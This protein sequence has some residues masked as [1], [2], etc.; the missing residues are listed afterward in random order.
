MQRK[1]PDG[2]RPG[3]QQMKKNAMFS[4]SI[5]ISLMMAG[6]ASAAVSPISVSTVNPAEESSSSPSGAAD[7]DM[8]KIVIYTPHDA[9]PMNAA[10][11]SFMADYP[12]IKVEVVDA[13][14]G[15]L[16]E[17]V[18][19]EAEHPAADVIWG[20]G[21]DS[22]AGHD[23][24][25]EAYTGA[26][27]ASIDAQFKDANGLWVGESP[28]PMVIIYNKKLLAAAGLPYPV[29]WADCLN[30][31]F[32][33]QIAYCQPSKSGSAYTQLCTM[34]LANGGQEDGWN[35]VE[36]FVANLDGKIFDSSSNCHKQV[37]AGE[38]MLGI[39][40]EKSAMT[41]AD[42]PDI[43]YCYPSEGTSSVPDAI[44]IIKNCPDEKNAQLFVDYVTSLQCQTEQSI[45]WSRR[46]V[47][48]DV[49]L[50][51]NMT[52]LSDINMVTYDFSWAAN[53]RN[54]NIAKFDALWE[55][56]QNG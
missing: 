48:T 41:Y 22:L 15:E 52:P 38:F 45:D 31:A 49:P 34:I 32:K 9:D 1:G 19:N 46:P 18:K 51:E 55:S 10:I 43:G 14:T 21:A 27:D 4:F 12:N 44:A 3:E 8:G 5:G 30:P 37:A 53:S 36:K 2:G 39:T 23:D 17:R 47:R 7:A 33:G 50:P 56:Y 26:N 11:T 20:G 6:C 35:Y 40:I 54:D 28:L 29:S 42:N 24:L 25:F 13:G 16:L